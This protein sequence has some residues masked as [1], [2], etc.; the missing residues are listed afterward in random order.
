MAD[1]QNPLS[2]PGHGRYRWTILA[3]AAAGFLIA[4]LVV[5]QLME[6]TPARWCVLAKQGSPE[7]ATGCFNVLLKLLE[8]KDHALM[9]LIGVLA[10]TIISIVVVALGVRINGAGPGGFSVDVGADKTKVSDGENEAVIPTP[11]S[12]GA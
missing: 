12:A 9:M 4:G 7:L 5:W 6:T 11:P 3:F 10:I 8:I 1:P 2:Q